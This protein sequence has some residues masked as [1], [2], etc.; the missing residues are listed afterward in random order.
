MIRPPPGSTRTDT[1]FPYTTLF[2]AGDKKL[3]AAQNEWP[4]PM[5]A[6]GPSLDINIAISTVKMLLEGA[7]DA[8]VVPDIDMLWSAHVW[9]CVERFVIET[10]L[11]IGRAHV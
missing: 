4:S 5:R 6:L 2:R 9:P 10:K 11:E 8:L 3:S 7:A 1:L